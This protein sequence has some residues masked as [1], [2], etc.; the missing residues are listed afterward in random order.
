MPARTIRHHLLDTSWVPWWLTGPNRGRI[1]WSFGLAMDAIMQRAQEATLQRF[2]LFCAPDALPWHGRD[3]RIVR[4]LVESTDSYRRRLVQWRKTHKKK[5]IAWGILENIQAYF[6]PQ[7]PVVRLVSGGTTAA[8]WWT[9]DSNGVRSFHRQ[10]P[11]NWD[12]DSAEPGQ[13]PIDT[14]R[15]FWVI[16]YQ[17]ETDPFV[18]FF[19]NDTS[20]FQDPTR[21]RGTAG[22]H[23]AADDLLRIALDWK[24][25]GTWCAGI[26]IAH[27]TAMWDPAGSGAGYPDGTWYRYSTPVTYLPVRPRTAEYFHDRRRPGLFQEDLTEGY[28]YP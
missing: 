15:R 6:L 11:S 25:A 9:I 17:D 19:P 2:P 5:G 12:W 14:Q 21:T 3:R 27:D 1:L 13:T 20:A 26:I 8:Q 22:L 18:M 7:V 10:T 28:Q 4:G 24:Q 23:A 16:I